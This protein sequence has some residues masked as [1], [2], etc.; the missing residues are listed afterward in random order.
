MISA[1]LQ[2]WIDMETIEALPAPSAGAGWHGLFWAPTRAHWARTPNV[3]P[4]V[5][6][7][8]PTS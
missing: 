1:R 5:P 3:N 4:S 7:I 8:A 2:K 6:L